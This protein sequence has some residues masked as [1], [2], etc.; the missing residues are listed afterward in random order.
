MVSRRLGIDR[1]RFTVE[2]VKVIT[3]DVYTLRLPIAGA[4]PQKGTGLTNPE[5]SRLHVHCDA[6]RTPRDAPRAPR[7]M[8]IPYS[9]SFCSRA[10]LTLNTAHARLLFLHSLTRCAQGRA[11]SRPRNYPTPP[12]QKSL[13]KKEKRASQNFG[14]PAHSN[15]Q[16][17]SQNKGLNSGNGVDHK[18]HRST[19]DPSCHKTLRRAGKHSKDNSSGDSPDT[20]LRSA[21]ALCVRRGHRR[22]PPASRA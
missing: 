16:S 21:A 12:F 2:R 19:G 14:T 5:S 15:G 9:E 4:L 11:I 3:S 17:K 10:F 22:S 7:Y 6:V 1:S 13:G 18:N 20:Q 8:L